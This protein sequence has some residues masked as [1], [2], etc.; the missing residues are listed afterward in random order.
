MRVKLFVRVDMLQAS[1][2][3]HYEEGSDI[4]AREDSWKMIHGMRRGYV[5]IDSVGLWNIIRQHS[6][7]R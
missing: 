1:R 6:A 4:W 3:C 5:L 2:E 7:L